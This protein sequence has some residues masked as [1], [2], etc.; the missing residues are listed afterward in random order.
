MNRS[1]VF[2]ELLAFSG[3]R[4]KGWLLVILAGLLLVGNGR[5]SAQNPDPFAPAFELPKADTP[6]PLS[7]PTP[8]AK[9]TTPPTPQEAGKKQPAG[10]GGVAEL[11][12]FT[13]RLEPAVARRNQKVLLILTGRLKPG[14][15]TYAYTRRTPEQYPT[16][17]HYDFPP[18]LQPLFPLQESEP[19]L[20]KEGD[21]GEFYEHRDTFTW[22]QEIWVQSAAQPGPARLAWRIRLQVC[23][24]RRCLPGTVQGEITLHISDEPPLALT[25]Q[26]QQELERR[27]RPPADGAA[28]GSSR[29]SGLLGFL[30]AGIFW[31]FVS[32]ITP[33]V[34]PMI[35]ITVSFFLKQSE[36]EHH[37]PITMALVYCGTIIVVLTVAAVA[38]L[39]L[40]RQ[41]SVNPVMNFA[42]GGLFLFF[43]L[44]LLGMYDIELPS[45]LA[46]FTSARENLG[47]LV[48]TMFMAL[49]FTIISFACV[50]PFLG[51]FGGMAAG[52]ELSLAHR[53]LGGLAF[54]TTFASPFFL[55]ALFPSL[56][57]KLPKSGSWLNSVKVVMGFLELAAA[58]KFL[59]AG[60]LM[61]VPESL[62]LTYD[63]VLGLYIA[64]S[65]LC[66]LYLL[67]L[68][69]L[70]NDS[71]LE[72]LSVPRLL[73]SLLF[74]GLGLYLT[75]AL[76]KNGERGKNQQPTGAL[77]AWVDAFLLPEEQEGSSLPWLGNL[78]EG[79]QRAR[80]EHKL[81]FL[82][83]T[84]KTCTNCKFNEEHIFTLPAIQE[85]L[86][87]YTLVQLYTDMVPRWLY[88][89]TERQRLGS[90][91]SQQRADAQ[92]NLEF[93]REKF[94]TEQLPLYVILEPLPDGGYREVSRYEEGKINSDAAFLR[95][96]QEALERSGVRGAQAE[97]RGRQPAPPRTVGVD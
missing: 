44:S 50:A 36:K 87:K 19:Q 35:P 69:R 71:P 37:R 27:S 26:E 85:Q 62:L 47:G 34:F 4:S 97:M 72:H 7:S 32:L 10:S 21:L 94:N 73:L 70:P 96:L 81:V 82:D 64:L 48:G 3:R 77:F 39:S 95:F 93:Q 55:L 92:R 15:H 63:F 65:L 24:A 74:I 56:L 5:L 76:F 43:A 18:G 45:G 33:C 23:D 6:A 41:L 16:E 1:G 89:P 58:L 66:G 54:A 86:K 2:Q 91:T 11:I 28:P 9:E 80:Q 79:L 29:S 78:Q 84:G 90:G 60:E 68:Y 59:R 49:T 12:E 75:P 88:P 22:K 51:G 17:I 25:P 8:A 42:I 57:K 40:F 83:F 67:G 52:V 20:V 13:A 61:V 14:Y 46:R 53:V 31:G 30:L 38:L